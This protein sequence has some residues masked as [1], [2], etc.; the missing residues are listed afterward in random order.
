MLFKKVLD[1]H[2]CNK[3]ETKDRLYIMSNDFYNNN[4]N[5]YGILAVTIFTMVPF[6][7]LIP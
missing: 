4:C 2:H 5:D 7:D 1:G 6:F 3:K